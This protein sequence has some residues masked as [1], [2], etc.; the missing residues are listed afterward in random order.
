MGCLKLAPFS[1]VALLKTRDDAL[2]AA[3][4]AAKEK[5]NKVI[6]RLCQEYTFWPENIHAN[7]TRQHS[8]TGV[9]A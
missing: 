3:V 9:A 6:Q 4:Y 7:N 5:G 1:K 8:M 2:K